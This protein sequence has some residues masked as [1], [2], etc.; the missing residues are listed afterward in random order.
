MAA[1]FEPIRLD[2][3]YEMHLMNLKKLALNGSLTI[4]AL[5]CIGWA[6]SWEAIRAID[7]VHSVRADFVQEKHLPILARPLLSKGR[8]LF[9][10]PQSLRWEYQ[11]PIRSILT[12]HA[13][14]TRR[15]VAGSSGWIEERGPGL[16]V[17]QVVLQE[18]TYWM[19]GRFDENPSFEARLEP[20]GRIVLTPRQEAFGTLIE[21]IV[22]NLGPLPGTLQSVEIHESREAFTRLTFSHMQLNQPI[23]EK[24]FGKAP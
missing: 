11:E 10:A 4:L 8:F 12:M 22:L 24:E 5:L 13:G 16:E 9:Q 6:D 23:D 18:I 20:D 7:P 21:R 14:K 17:M 2:C 15:F 1:C 3:F 19:A